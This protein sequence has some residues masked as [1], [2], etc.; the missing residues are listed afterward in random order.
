MRL[1]KMTGGLGN[2]MFIYAFYM[3]MK[4][5]F[6][7]TRIDLSDM[8]HYRVHNGYELH[9]IFRHLP[10]DEFCINQKVKKVIEFLFFKTILERK[11]N[12]ETLRAFKCRRLWPLVYFKG[13]YQDERYFADI[14][15][16][17]RQA[18]A[19][20]VALANERTRRLLNQIDADDAAVS[21]HVR[22]GDYL[23]GSTWRTT[24][25]I[26]QLPYYRDAVKA[27]EAKVKAPHYYVFSDDIDWAVANLPLNN[28]TF[29]TWNHGDE[30]WQDMLLMSHCR[31][32]II[33]N[34]T[35]S[36]WGA[37]LGHNPRKTVVAPARWSTVA[38]MPHICPPSWTLIP[39][40][41]SAS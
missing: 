28:A 18:F 29:I 34:S 5:R 15:D 26:C 40:T 11:Q 25:C 31:H 30:S 10:E 22:R 13:F 4:R 6:A 12:L 17:V 32:H 36:W 24:G 14:A 21:L 35:F 33:C 38:E 9:R 7:N 16:E 23:K 8:M 19:F 41:P 39:V 2:Q 37:W 27:M 20:D 1:I 3:Q